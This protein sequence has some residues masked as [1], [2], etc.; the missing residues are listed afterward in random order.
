[1][2]D[3]ALGADIRAAATVAADIIGAG[4]TVAAYIIGGGAE[5]V[6]AGFVTGKAK[7]KVICPT[8]FFNRLTPSSNDVYD[9]PLIVFKIIPHI[10]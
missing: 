5:V 1:M 8:A 9:V 2:E 10:N 7:T 6:N 3:A 4:A